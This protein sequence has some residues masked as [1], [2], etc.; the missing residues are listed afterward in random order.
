MPPQLLAS[1]PHSLDVVGDIAIIEIPPEL[2]SSKSI[3]GEA[4]MQVHRNV[5][6]VLAKASK[7]SGTF[8]LRELEFIAGEQRTSTQYKENGCIYQVDVAK[9]YFSPRLSHERQRVAEQ[10]HGGEVVVDLFAG[11]GP[12]AVLMAKTH[13]AKVFAVDINP[14]A[15]EFLQRNVRLN[16][17]ENRVFPIVGDARKIIKDQ[18]K[19]A[20]DRVIMNLPET[21]HEFID[22]A[23][24][25]LKPGGGIVHFYGFVRAPD[26][27]EN[28][29]SRFAE[30]TEKA[31]RKV[32]AFR[33]SK[34]VRE[35]APFE[36][37]AVLDAEIV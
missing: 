11:V 35:T 12:F 14:D 5:C 9:A 17:V 34:P 32:R 2:K 8:R 20:A 26:T 21:A 4:I 24:K 23:C 33:E 15:I 37:Q 29:Q 30:A 28:L 19:G 22:V 27:I 10:V 18:L 36:C 7:V 3:V 16:R 13:G 25:A 1:L 6:V 31:G